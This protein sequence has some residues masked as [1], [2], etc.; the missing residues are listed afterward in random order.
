MTLGERRSLFTRLLGPLLARMI[1]A[2]LEPRI[3][4]VQRPGIAALFYGYGEAQ[5]D[6]IAALVSPEFS[7]LADEIHKLRSV[8]GSKRS[9]HLEALAADIVLC[10]PGGVPL[11]KTSDHEPFGVF[12]EGLHPLCC[13]GG[14]FGDGG[15]YSLTPDGVR[16]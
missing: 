15:H 1:A 11:T 4:E 10:K 3:G 6:R 5:C 2:G 8:M 16:K 7:T 9:V 12:W 14:R 13:W